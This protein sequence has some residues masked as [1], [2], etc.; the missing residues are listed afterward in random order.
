M[1]KQEAGSMG[2][3]ATVRKYGRD[4][5]VNI[6]KRGAKTL[7]Q[8]YSLLPYQLNKYALIDRSS[9]EVRAVR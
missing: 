1:T 5:M 7:W 6:G 2:G 4:Y 8:R 9:G 3:L